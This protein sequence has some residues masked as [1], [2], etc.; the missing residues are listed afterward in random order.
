MKIRSISIGLKP[1]T[2][3]A[4]SLCNVREWLAMAAQNFRQQRVYGGRGLASLRDFSV[5]FLPE[6]VLRRIPLSQARP[7]LVR[8][9]VNS[10]AAKYELIG[11]YAIYRQ[12]L[13]LSPLPRPQ[14]PHQGKS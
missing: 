9:E 14:R 6:P 2:T 10:R 11:R 5:I 8:D 1:V 7:H 13:F 4:T 3:R 12:S